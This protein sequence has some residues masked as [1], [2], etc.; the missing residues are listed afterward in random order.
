MSRSAS[1]SRGR[2][3]YV[4]T[5]RGGSGNLIRSPSRNNYGEEGLVAGSERG[6]TLSPVPVGGA[7]ARTE[8]RERV[9]IHAGRGGLGNTRSP[10]VSTGA[11]RW[12]V[13]CVPPAHGH[14]VRGESRAQGGGGERVESERVKRDGGKKIELAQRGARFEAGPNGSRARD[15]PVPAG[16]TTWSGTGGVKEGRKRKWSPPPFPPALLPTSGFVDSTQLG[17]ETSW[18]GGRRWGGSPPV[19]VAATSRAMVTP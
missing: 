12:V 18:G 15:P 10:S 13:V 16:A 19:W 5:G 8:S 14:V 4:S 1:Q 9:V 6:R 11:P 17:R 2:S 3:D 7:G